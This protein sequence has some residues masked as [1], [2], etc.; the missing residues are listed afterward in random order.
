MDDDPIFADHVVISASCV[1]RIYP[2]CRITIL[3]DDDSWKNLGRVGSRLSEVASTVRSVGKTA[4][5]PRL[6]SRFVKTQARNVIDGDFLYLDADTAPISEFGAV[7]GCEAAVSAAIDR[8][9]VDP[10]GGFPAWVV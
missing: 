6:R 5:S 2:A 8:N 10:H 4:G 1:K 3:T 9:L 7:F